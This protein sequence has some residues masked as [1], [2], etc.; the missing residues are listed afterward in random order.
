V[1]TIDVRVEDPLV[2]KKTLFFKLPERSVTIF[3]FRFCTHSLHWRNSANTTLLTP[4]LITSTYST[5]TGVMWKQKMSSPDLPFTA[6][7][8]L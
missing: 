4:T 6:S 3:C 5:A 2:G 7:F 8:T 1:L